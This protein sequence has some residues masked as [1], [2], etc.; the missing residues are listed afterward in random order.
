MNKHHPAPELLAA[1]AAGNL[2]L[3]QAL[4]V[5]THIDHC[6][7]CQRELRRLEQLG[8]QLFVEQQPAPASP[9]LK[10]QVMAMLDQPA[11]EATA[12][13]VSP[14]A[15][16]VPRSLQ[17]F[18]PHSREQ[19]QWRYVSPAIRSA[20]L[21]HDTE[22]EEVALLWIKA[23]SKIRHHRH[24]GDELTVVLEGSF[25]D[26]SG[27]YQ[28]GDFVL[29][30]SRHQHAPVVSKDRDCICLAVT[31]QPI[32]FTGFFSRL[33]NPLVRRAHPAAG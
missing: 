12:P 17:Q 21:C 14:V 32:Q 13:I 24:K 20:V 23:G 9:Q 31:D 7:S 16:N 30:D 22:G 19:L 10:D 33:L 27:I 25:S 3:S 18:V 11:E 6:H 29:R 2:K 1:F 8:S 15:S 26:Q 4:C 28:A 5:G